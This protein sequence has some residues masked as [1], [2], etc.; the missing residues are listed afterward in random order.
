MN[1][2]LV[3]IAW[4]V[5]PSVAAQAVP[6]PKPLASP[7][8]VDLERGHAL[9]DAHCARCHGIGGAGGMG[10]ALAGVKLQ[11]APDDERLLAVLFEGIPGTPM[12]AAWQLADGELSR[13]AAYVST[14][15]RVAPVAPPGDPAR[16]KALYDGKGVC[17][18]CHIVRGVG[19]GRGPELTDIGGRRGLEYLR[20]SLLDPGAH[21]PERRVPYEPNAYAAYLVVRAVPRQGE[22]IAG[23]RV[24]EDS[25]TIQVRDSAGTLRSLRK[26]DLASLEKQEAASPMP[27]YRGLTDGEIDDLV[28]YLASLRGTP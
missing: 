9:F 20:E 10:P 1:R 5:A 24:N 15:G 16:G 27:S 2:V 3:L 25:F 22:P 7:T 13:V 11:R 12:G 8:A 28:A 18:T 14:L 21:L 6:P 4:L 23:T 17:A 26:A 19:S